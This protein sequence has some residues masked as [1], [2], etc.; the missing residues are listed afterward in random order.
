VKKPRKQRYR[1]LVLV[2]GVMEIMDLREAGDSDQTLEIIVKQ[3]RLGRGYWHTQPYGKEDYRERQGRLGQYVEGPNGIF[4]V[5]DPK[6][7]SHREE[8]RRI[9]REIPEEIRR[10]NGSEKIPLT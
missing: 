5:Y 3:D 6:I 1:A 4:C 8:A 2:D 10:R 7:R 9:T